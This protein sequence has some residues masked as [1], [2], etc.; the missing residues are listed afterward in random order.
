MKFLA[1]L[2]FML[3][4]S[5]AA[6]TA[7]DARDALGRLEAAQAELEEATS[8]RDRVR[9]LTET[10]HAFEDGLSA[11]RSGLRR[12]GAREADLAA[13]LQRRD[14]EIAG[15]LSTLHGV[16]SGPSPVMM[17]HPQGPAGSARAGMILTAL[18]PELNAR[19]I[20]LREDL[21]ELQRLQ[22]LQSDA[23]LRLSEGLTD[24]RQA[25][26]LLSEAIADRKELPRRF[27]NDPVREAILIASAD[28]LDSFARGLERISENET[29]EPWLAAEVPQGDLPLPAV[30]DVRRAAGEA[31]A[32]GVV[33]PGIVLGTL[34]GALVTAPV[35][36]TVRYAGALLD[37]G[38]VVIIEPHSDVLMIFA[39]LETLYGAAGEVVGAGAP[40]GL[41]GGVQATAETEV[42]TDSD[43][44]GAQAT[45][46]LYIEVRKNN[47]PEDPSLWFRTDKDR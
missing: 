15:L 25:R 11:V 3:P 34:P 33:R 22:S 47:V 1:V 13:D 19:A 37:F 24:L 12:A 42:S 32:A 36:A 4:V 27:T 16:G 38:N 40:L 8:A 6:D 5:L 41:M 23:E 29:G 20:G 10:I 28:T 43:R 45:E 26:A 14:K 31:D 18:A 46:T 39:G 30:G 9:A 17:L 2:I 21:Q 7:Q 35:D 44:T